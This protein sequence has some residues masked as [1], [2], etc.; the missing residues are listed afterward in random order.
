MFADIM[1]PGLSAVGG[2]A[3]PIRDC[4]GGGDCIGCTCSGCGG[5][6]GGSYEVLWPCLCRTRH[7]GAL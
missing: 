1:G 4:A 5:C 2:A 7:L 6:G 3:G